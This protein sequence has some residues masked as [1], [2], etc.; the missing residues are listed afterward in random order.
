MRVCFYTQSDGNCSEWRAAIPARELARR[1]HS[2][3]LTDI[4]DL[5]VGR[6][7]EADVAIVQRPTDRVYLESFRELRRRG[8]RVLA[9]VDDLLWTGAIPASNPAFLYY[10]P[11][12]VRRRVA[13][14]VER[15][16]RRY[17]DVPRNDMREAM[18]DCLKAAD[19]VVV[20]TPA[21]ATAARRL[22]RPVWVVPNLWDNHNPAWTAAREERNGEG[23]NLLF[24]G[25][26]THYA[27]LGLL[28]GVLET[29][30]REE[31]NVKV[32]LGADR[33]LLTLFNLPAGRLE[34]L[35]GVGFADYP[36]TLARGDIILAPLVD[37][38]FNRSKSDIRL[39]EAGALERPWV[40][41]PTPAYTGWGAGG[42]FAGNPREWL[43]RLRQLVRNP[44]R[45]RALGEEGRQH[46]E[47][48]SIEAKGHL[49]E[50][51]LAAVGKE[52]KGDGDDKRR[53]NRPGAGQSA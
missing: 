43:A 44:D 41:S 48:W 42:L 8:Q 39:M 52:P 33:R 26:Y 50:E 37:C 31:E 11:R 25:S 36:H 40:G 15:G 12:R 4:W 17:E 24:A 51:M 30:C 22:G 9:E 32:L 27:D 21:L 3:V 16:T 1:G 23:V 49:W 6:Y 13:E 18:V 10:H 7:H 46:A 29:L 47:E 20:T 5:S 34:Y 19:G 28:R 53:A 45:R 14:E 38:Q 35:P 2:V